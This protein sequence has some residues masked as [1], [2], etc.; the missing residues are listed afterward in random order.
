MS[1]GIG[2]VTATFVNARDAATV[3]A[4]SRLQVDSWRLIRMPSGELH[5]ATLRDL[6]E[7]QA[8]VRVTSAL[9]SL[10]AVTGDATTSSGRQYVLMGPP[11]TRQSSLTL[12]HGGAA[13]LGLGDAVD[14]SD[15]VWA[16]LQR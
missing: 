15:L 10:D 12:L 4:Q 7:E 11:E 8:T 14:I 2:P 16:E 9:S 6:S 13:S 3:E 1:E 5:L